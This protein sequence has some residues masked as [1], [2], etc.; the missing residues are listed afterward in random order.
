MCVC[1]GGGCLCVGAIFDVANLFQSISIYID[2]YR[3]II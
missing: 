3:I 2:I 1:V